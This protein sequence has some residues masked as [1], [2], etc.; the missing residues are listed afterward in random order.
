MAE[1]TERF[2]LEKPEEDDY[3]EV[4]VHNRNMDK[5]DANAVKS[6]DISE[7]RVLTEDA[8]NSAAPEET[9]LYVL[10]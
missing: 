9:V 3:Y 6:C 7:I 2:L 4:G 8:Y 5:L 10:I 1:L